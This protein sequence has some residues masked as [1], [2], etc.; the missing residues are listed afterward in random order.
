MDNR[1]DLDQLWIEHRELR[2]DFY[3]HEA[4]GE[5]RWKTIFNELREVQ[6]TTKHIHDELKESIN[7][8][9]KL[10]LTVSGSIIFVLAGALLT[11]L[12]PRI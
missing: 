1:N 10:V 11:E 5:E 12:G 3:T 6:D 9:H 2:Q 4:V 7:S 8:L